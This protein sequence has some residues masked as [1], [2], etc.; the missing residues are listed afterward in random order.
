MPTVRHVNTLEERGPLR[1]VNM[2]VLTKDCVSQHAAAH[3]LIQRALTLFLHRVSATAR[4]TI[5]STWRGRL[6][7]DR[8]ACGHWPT[9]RAAA[10]VCDDISMANQI[11]AQCLVWVTVATWM[12]PPPIAIHYQ[13]IQVVGFQYMLHVT[14]SLGEPQSHS[15]LANAKKPCAPTPCLIITSGQK[16]LTWHRKQHKVYFV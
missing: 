2:W 12:P 7:S 16:R 4:G 6:C 8:R 9:M 13:G 1:T 11:L 5:R 10:A 14:F 3:W 15:F